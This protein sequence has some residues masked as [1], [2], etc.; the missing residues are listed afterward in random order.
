MCFQRKN[1]V[2]VIL[3][4]IE[5]H[6]NATNEVGRRVALGKKIEMQRARTPSPIFGGGLIKFFIFAK[7]NEIKFPL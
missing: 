3:N 6:F 5:Y 4:I 2:Q 1:K 7:N